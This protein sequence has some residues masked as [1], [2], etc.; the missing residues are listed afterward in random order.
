M[1]DDI[2]SQ[3]PYRC[4]LDWGVIGTERAIHRGDIIV[5]VDVLSFLTTTA[6]AVSRGALIIP[7]SPSE[8]A[9]ELARKIGGE[10][11]VKR[12][13]VPALGRYSLSPS[14]FA[15][16]VEGEKIVLPSLNGS[17]CSSRRATNHVFAGA[18]VNATAVAS[19][20]AGLLSQGSE[21][22]TVIACGER[23]KQPEP[24]GDLRPAVEDWLGAGAIIA[25]LNVS[26]SPEARLAEAA[27]V[28][29]AQDI[30]AL[31]WDCVSGRELREAGFGEDV[32]FAS[33]LDT[34]DVAPV[35]RD[36]A[37]VRS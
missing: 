21:S 24:V 5:I 26:K 20:V 6:Y 19:A 31:L 29:S 23:E 27:F 33:G 30:A 15:E 22:V 2:F 32:R 37:F 34:I 13:D 17:T 28:G 18:L 14:T 25:G 12:P 4:R 8:D 1:S 7:C 36:G 10:A 3:S 9:R 11:A 16:V 35:L